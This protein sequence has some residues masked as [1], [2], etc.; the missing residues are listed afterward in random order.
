MACLQHFITGGKTIKT[1]KTANLQHF[2]P[3]ND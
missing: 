2:I 3:A 1:Q